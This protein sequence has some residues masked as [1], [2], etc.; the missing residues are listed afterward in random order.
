MEM[1]L[2]HL[3]IEGVADLVDPDALAEQVKA[4]TWQRDAAICALPDAAR[5]GNLRR[6]PV[7]QQPNT[8]E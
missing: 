1:A 6:A 5:R 2:T 4:I 7:Q 3:Y 8:P